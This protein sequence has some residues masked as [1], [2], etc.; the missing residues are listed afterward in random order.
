VIAVQP[1]CANAPSLAIVRRL[2][3]VQTGEYWDD[4]DGLE[5]V[6]ELDVAVR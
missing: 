2:G 1:I 6:F 4:E 3:F 5:L